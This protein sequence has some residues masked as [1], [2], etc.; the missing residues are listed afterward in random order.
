MK[1]SLTIFVLVLLTHIPAVKAQDISQVCKT[2]GNAPLAGPHSWPMK[3]AVKVYF[4]K[5]TFT[6]EQQEALLST[7]TTWTR[8]SIQ[9]GAGVT[10]SYAGETNGV[11]SC[12]DCL[13][14]TRWEA[15]KNDRKPYALF[16]RVKMNNDG[17]LVSAWIKLYVDT[18]SPRA[19]QGFM[20]H[21]LGHGLGLLDC[22]SCKKNQTIMNS[23]PG[24]NQD[25]GLI[26]PSRCDLEVV[27]EV[28]RKQRQSAL[29]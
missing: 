14:I 12:Q 13:T 7:M 16:V 17:L 2:N 28:Y 29:P 8:A 22:T 23:F 1:L 27:R 5:N 11:A 21:E 18:T 6:S 4:S 15:Y 3:A 20:A 9:V 24:I 26:S 25:N 19:L 10:F